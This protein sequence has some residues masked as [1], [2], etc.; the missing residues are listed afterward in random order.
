MID[1]PTEDREWLT[2]GEMRKRLRVSSC[3][4]AHLREEGRLLFRKDGNAFLYD[5]RVLP[6]DDTGKP[7]RQ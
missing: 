6:H 1:D 7:T 2:S 4:L 5:P 3:Q